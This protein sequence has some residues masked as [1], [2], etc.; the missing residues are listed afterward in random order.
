VVALGA[1]RGLLAGL[2]PDLV[3]THT[4]KAGALGR[5]AAAALGIPA[6][7]TPHAWPFQMDVAPVQAA[8]W[9]STERLLARL[10]AH[11]VDVSEHECDAALAARVGSPGRHV[12][13]P[14]GVPDVPPALRADPRRE[15]P[16]LT[17]VARF[18]PQKDH[19]GLLRALA[20]L[21]RLP[22]TADLVGDGPGQAEARSLARALGLQD[23][24]TFLGARTDVPELLA[25]AQLAVL[26]TRWE[27]LPL[28]VLEAMR[29]GLPVLASEVGGVGEAVTHGRNG[30]LVAPGDDVGLV[31]ALRAL[32]TDAELRARLGEAGRRRYLGA[33][34]HAR[35][36]DQVETLYRRTVGHPP[37][38]RPAP[39][40]AQMEK[41]RV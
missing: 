6:V 4:A 17:M 14:N 20:R 15:P 30:L 13:I 37:P 5:A 35:M 29:A 23:R 16:R 32:L 18:E 25:D 36:L 24:V 41:G 31:A 40:A 34:T 33:F 22:W 8:I 21:S 10:P 1:L 12:V 38:P 26:T 2:R 28:A 27:S 7:H 9:R 19:A 3:A 11:L 39:A